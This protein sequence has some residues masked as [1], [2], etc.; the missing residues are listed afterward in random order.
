MEGVLFRHPLLLPPCY[1]AIIRYRSPMKKR[2]RLLEKLLPAGADLQSVPI[3]F[4]IKDDN[5]QI[6]SIQYNHLNLPVHIDIATKPAQE[7]GRIEYLYDAA[8]IKLRQTK[9]IG[10]TPD[11]ETNYIG[12]FAYEGE[13]SLKYI[14]T[15]DGR[16]IPKTGGGFE[17][18]YFIKD[19]LG[20]T[21]LTVQDSSGFAAIKQE[22]HYYPFGMA[23]GGQSWRDS[24]Q[25][26][27]NDYLYNGKEFQDELGLD[28]YDYGARFYDAVIGRWHGV[29]PLAE[30]GFSISPYVYV[31][32]NPMAFI[33]PDG[34]WPWNKLVEGREYGPRI[35]G[36]AFHPS[37]KHPIYGDIRP[38]NGVDFGKIPGKSDPVGGER[39]RVAA[40]GKVIQVSYDSRSGYNIVVEHANGYTTSYCHLKE[41][42]ELVEV[43]QDVEDG[44]FIAGMG[45]TGASNS[46]HLHFG[47]KKDGKWIDPTKI[48]DLDKFLDP[49]SNSAR[50]AKRK[51]G[52]TPILKKGVKVSKPSENATKEEKEFW[53]ESVKGIM[54]YLKRLGTQHM[55]PDKGPN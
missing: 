33:D 42:S 29:D 16:L 34:N 14:I 37:R 47:M 32:N 10:A 35:E 28:W 41:G 18:E 11:E 17:Y 49:K 30:K 21:R 5:K 8:G 9:Y 51:L 20:N 48:D 12:N 53:D 7:G 36:N 3:L 24:T 15:D 46:V 52:K 27:K 6:T 25:T 2:G 43:G 44:Q 40:K 55:N 19:H 54:D 26:T 38:H 50:N 1:C 31:F 39:I 23:L 13:S 22:N 45:S 4:L